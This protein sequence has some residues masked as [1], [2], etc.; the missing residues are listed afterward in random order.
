LLLIFFL[1]I[2]ALIG[3]GGLLGYI[4]GKMN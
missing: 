1:L 3:V 2:H 4:G